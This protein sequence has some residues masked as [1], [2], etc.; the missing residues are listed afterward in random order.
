MK[1]TGQSSARHY[2]LTM[3]VVSISLCLLL[4]FAKAYGK[5]VEGHIKTLEVSDECK[6]KGKKIENL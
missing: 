2:Q 4:I 5:Y 1:I 3:Y 6:L